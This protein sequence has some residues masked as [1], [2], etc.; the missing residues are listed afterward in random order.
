M[1]SG[2]DAKC[3][4]FTGCVVRVSVVWC[5]E[6]LNSTLEECLEEVNVLY[7]VW[8]FCRGRLRNAGAHCDRYWNC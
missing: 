3:F 8:L 1:E 4:A 2:V 7:I 6:V 5:E